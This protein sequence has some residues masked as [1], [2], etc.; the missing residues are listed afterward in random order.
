VLSLESFISRERKQE[1]KKKELTILDR[2]KERETKIDVKKD[3]AGKISM[4]KKH[5]K[6]GTCF[7]CT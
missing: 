6:R 2:K 3:T 4:E 5:D 1:R 7:N